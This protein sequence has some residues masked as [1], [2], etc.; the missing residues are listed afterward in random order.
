MSKT[1]TNT[2][3]DEIA[4]LHQAN[5]AIF[6]AQSDAELKQAIQN[7][8][9]SHLFIALYYIVTESGLELAFSH[10]SKSPLV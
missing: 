1:P 3:F 2:D 10:D 6:Q 9:K 4:R 7:A 5:Y 8:L